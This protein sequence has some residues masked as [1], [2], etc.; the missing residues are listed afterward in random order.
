VCG[1]FSR[2]TSC[3]SRARVCAPV[4]RAVVDRGLEPYRVRC[5]A[6]LRVRQNHDHYGNVTAEV[7]YTAKSDRWT[8]PS[9]YYTFTKEAADGTSIQVCPS[10]ARALLGVGRMRVCG[11]L[12][13]V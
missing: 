9:L 1:C 6:F 4:C 3:V 12:G 2:A 5:D 10:S 11:S 13:V 7:A 8:F